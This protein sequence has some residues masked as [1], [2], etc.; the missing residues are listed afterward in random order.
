M[1]LTAG[2]TGRRASA[3]SGPLARAR[4]GHPAGLLG[5]GVLGPLAQREDQLLMGAHQGA[6]ATVAFATRHLLGLAPV[7]GTFALRDGTVIV[8][9]PVTGSA[10]QARVAASSFRSGNPA[11]WRWFR[12]E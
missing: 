4:L 3:R 8:T 5:F 10:V 6:P 2:A 11:A 7:R 1:K 12:W 9:D